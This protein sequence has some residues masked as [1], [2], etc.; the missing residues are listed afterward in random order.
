MVIFG[1][2]LEIFNIITLNQDLWAEYII[3]I[4]ALK[5]YIFKD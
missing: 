1:L 4:D 2:F 5:A 3:Y